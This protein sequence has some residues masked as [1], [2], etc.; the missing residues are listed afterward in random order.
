VP[1]SIPEAPVLP[2][3]TLHHPHL[4][5]VDPDAVIDFYARE[6]ASTSR[7]TRNGEPALDCANA[8]FVLSKQR[9]VAW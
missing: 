2:T 3:P 7:T 4:N 5:S 9:D 1:T 6:F 8:T